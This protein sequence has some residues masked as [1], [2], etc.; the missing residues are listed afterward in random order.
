VCW[1]FFHFHTINRSSVCVCNFARVVAKGA[2]Q[3]HSVRSSH[4]TTMMPPSAAHF[5]NK[6]KK[7][8]R[9]HP[10]CRR[11][12]TCWEQPPGD[13]I[14][15]QSSQ[16]GEICRAHK[17][18]FAR[19]QHVYEIVCRCTYCTAGHAHFVCSVWLN[20]FTSQ[21]LTRFKLSVRDSA[22]LLGIKDL[23]WDQFKSEGIKSI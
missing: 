1:S 7:G 16:K 5:N 13:L 9:T 21:A 14:Y 3:M 18:L 17:Y 11:R 4:P 8:T 10:S 22:S 6:I 12:F 20:L 23:W 2:R 19:P 15:L